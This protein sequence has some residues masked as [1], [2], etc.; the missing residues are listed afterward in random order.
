MNINLPPIAPEHAHFAQW[1]DTPE[2]CCRLYPSV[3]NDHAIL[4]MKLGDAW[5]RLCK[6]CMRA[7]REQTAR[8]LDLHEKQ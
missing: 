2:Q 3:C 7:M 5:Y 8:I 4:N 1:L 6:P